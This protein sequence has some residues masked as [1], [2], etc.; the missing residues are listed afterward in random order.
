MWTNSR[1]QT[2]RVLKPWAQDLQKY[3]GRLV[4]GFCFSVVA[5][6][7]GIALL[8]FS[9]WFISAAGLIGLFGSGVIVLNIYLT[10]GAIRFFALSR[11]VARYFERLSQHDAVLRVQSQSRV[12]I[13]A[14][15]RQGSMDSMKAF[16]SGSF[17]HRLLQDV[18]T[19]NG[20]WLRIFSPL[21]LAGLV[22]FVLS[23][24]LWFWSPWITFGVLGFMVV[25]IATCLRLMHSVA[26]LG[27]R[28]HVLSER[29]YRRTMDG[30]AGR[31]ELWCWGQGEYYFNQLAY[32]RQ[33]IDRL[34]QKR[35]QRVRRANT[36]IQIAFYTAFLWVLAIMAVVPTVELAS[37]PI[38]L[39]DLGPASIVMIA[40]LLLAVSEAW[41]ALPDQLSLWGSILAAARRTEPQNDKQ[42]AEHQLSLNERDES[43]EGL[44]IT[45]LSI[46]HND[47]P[48]L[49]IPELRVLNGEHLAI[50]GDS[51]AGKSSLADALSGQG[52][53]SKWITWQG[54]SL[55]QFTDADCAAHIGYLSQ[56][57]TVL[58]G[59]LW[60]N[61]VI[62]KRGLRVEEANEV[63]ALADLS[64]W[65]QGLP[66]G[67]HTRLDDESMPLSGGQ[68]RR[69]SWARLLL[70]NPQLVIL[71]EPFYSL[72]HDTRVRLE[73]GVEDWL[74]KRTVISFAHDIQAVP[75][76][77]RAL[78]IQHG[79]LIAHE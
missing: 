31:D 76:P 61:L 7:S 51:G 71:D 10:G 47:R 41:L 60:D 28:H 17:V 38:A 15:L 40:L 9:G 36:I 23:L 69:L 16:H 74:A 56:M 49:Q 58:N 30:L 4:L 45:E 2:F 43:F 1:N 25:C 14:D 67:Y 24:L 55:A 72:D 68:R 62:A 65:W 29:L 18:D 70:R 19:M 39:P 54:R 53:E 22:T 75:S 48:V 59:T 8:G 27:A 12:R 46:I 20:L 73:K 13:F 57:D 34:H 21:L 3:T 64:G 63:L 66:E 42:L 50:I 52:R 78:R 77:H 5:L 33:R 37:V 44:Q 79:K 11:T 32:L 35:Q 26:S 6:A